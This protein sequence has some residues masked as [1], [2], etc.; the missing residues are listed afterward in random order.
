MCYCLLFVLIFVR[1][2]NLMVRKYFSLNVQI[3]RLRRLLTHFHI[4]NT[5]LVLEHYIRKKKALVTKRK[6]LLGRDKDVRGN[7]SVKVQIF[8]EGN[9]YQRLPFLTWKF[10]ENRIKSIKIMVSALL[11]SYYL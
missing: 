1:M 6:L 9:L 10:S 4:L 5:K 7:N 8:C 2:V 11:P 3:R